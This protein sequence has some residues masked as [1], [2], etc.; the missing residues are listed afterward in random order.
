MAIM[1][2]L[3]GQKRDLLLSGKKIMEHL[4]FLF[5]S[6]S[7]CLFVVCLRVEEVVGAPHGEGGG[8]EP[9]DGR[10]QGGPAQEAVPHLLA[11]EFSRWNLVQK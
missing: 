1:A 2:F 9:E 5:F 3:L 10:R 11:K 8:Q 4:L 6:L 7:L